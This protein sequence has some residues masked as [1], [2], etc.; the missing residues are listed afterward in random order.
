MSPNPRAVISTLDAS[1]GREVPCLG[2]K[3]IVVL[4]SAGW[5]FA[6]QA[7]ELL[8][9]RGEVPLSDDEMTRCVPCADAWHAR[10]GEKYDELIHKVN[11]AQKLA[12]ETGRVDP[13][14]VDWL[15]KNGFVEWAH[16][17]ESACKKRQDGQKTGRKQ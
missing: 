6:R 11:K 10:R 15:R 8:V 12:K 17:L 4:S 5:D 3:K 2:C 14:I 13:V 9:E 16:G 1:R 7:S